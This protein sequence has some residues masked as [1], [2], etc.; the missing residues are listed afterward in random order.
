MWPTNTT[1]FSR[2]QIKLSYNWLVWHE[3]NH[4]GTY[5]VSLLWKMHHT[6]FLPLLFQHLCILQCDVKGNEHCQLHLAR[7][8]FQSFHFLLAALWWWHMFLKCRDHLLAFLSVPWGVWCYFHNFSEGAQFLLSR[9]GTLH[10]FHHWRILHLS[11]LHELHFPLEF[12]G[13][14]GPTVCHAF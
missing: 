6:L 14:Q 9:E 2:N 11:T 12:V 10:I 13:F 1:C 8:P 4:L 7:P 5:L 3:D